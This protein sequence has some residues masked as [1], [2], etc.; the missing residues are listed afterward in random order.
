LVKEKRNDERK[1]GRRTDKRR[2][3]E[4]EIR[5]NHV[6]IPERNHGERTISAKANLLGDLA[7]EPSREGGM[8]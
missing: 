6:R 1:R 4:R 5:A 7:E 2:E 3:R 8:G